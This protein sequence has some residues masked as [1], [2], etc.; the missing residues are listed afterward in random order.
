MPDHHQPTAITTGIT[1]A[2]ARHIVAARADQLP[3][4]VRAE[5]V[6][7]FL[8]WMGC[9]VGAARHEAVDIAIKALTP[10]AGKPQAT[11]LG[12]H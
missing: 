2:L 7:T 12:R 5:A 8:N 3:S 1:R 6:R 11:I 10:F 4:A 9:A